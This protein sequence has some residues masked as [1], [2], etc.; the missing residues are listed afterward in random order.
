MRKAQLIGVY[1][2]ECAIKSA[3]RSLCAIFGCFYKMQQHDKSQRYN[4]GVVCT[5]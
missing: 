3:W 2:F 1:L 5:F 4:V